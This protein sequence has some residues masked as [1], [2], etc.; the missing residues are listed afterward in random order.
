MRVHLQH[1]QQSI[2]EQVGQLSILKATVLR[3]DQHIQGL[4]KG[5]SSPAGK[6]V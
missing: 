2:E 5:S 4:L 3:N 6:I 1:L